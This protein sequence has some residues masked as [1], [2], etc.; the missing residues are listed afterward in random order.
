VYLPHR[1][2]NQSTFISTSCRRCSGARRGRRSPSLR[3]IDEAPLV[4]V[5]LRL[6]I[7]AVFHFLKYIP[8][9]IE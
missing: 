6:P 4:P 9:N 1:N 2:T 5:Q 8:I 3:R 7:G